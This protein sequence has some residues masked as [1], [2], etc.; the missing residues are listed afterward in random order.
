MVCVVVLLGR[1]VTRLRPPRARLDN[2][3]LMTLWCVCIL[4][5]PPRDRE[6]TQIP[7]F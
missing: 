6:R 3:L 5:S 1:D 7:F 2:D 4:T